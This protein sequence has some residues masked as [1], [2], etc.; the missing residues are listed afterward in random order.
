MADSR[1]PRAF[2]G[3]AAAG[4]TTGGRQTKLGSSSSSTSLAPVVSSTR[5]K[6]LSIGSGG[7]GK[8]CLIKRY[9]EDRFVQKYIATIGIDY[10]V[11]PVQVD[12]AEVRVN[13]WDLSGHPEF[14]EV[15]NEFYK[16][17]QGAMLVF[18]VSSRASF[19]ELDLWLQEAAKFGANP[20]EIPIALCANKVDKKRVV[21]E[22]EGR[23]YALSRGMSYFETSASTGQSVSDMFEFVFKAIVRAQSRV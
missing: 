14:F 11:K 4:A 19:D 22:E 7:C 18:D 15:R 21:S 8:S 16:D 20:K 9:C 3:G 6:L 2:A 17:T 23:Q 13:F 12:G 10:G 5:I 1:K